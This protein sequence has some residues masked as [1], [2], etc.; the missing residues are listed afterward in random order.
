LGWG[1]DCARDWVE[2]RLHELGHGQ[3]A[4]FPAQIEHLKVPQGERDKIV[5]EQ[6]NYFAAQAK[7]MNYDQTAERDWPIGSG[8]VES[9]CSGAQSQLE[10][11]G[12]FWTRKCLANLAAPIDARENNY[13]DHLWFAG[14]WCY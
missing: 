12:E 5:R 3:G 9:A 2:S 13:W 7:R 6:K 8:A 1:E 4:K 14:Q 11:R 10:R